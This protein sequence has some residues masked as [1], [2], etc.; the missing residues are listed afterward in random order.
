MSRLT[1]KTCICQGLQ[2]RQKERIVSKLYGAYCWGVY[3]QTLNRYVV[4]LVS[5]AD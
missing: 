3:D 2:E 1:G 4:M 5:A